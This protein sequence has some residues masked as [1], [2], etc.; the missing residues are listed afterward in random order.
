MPCGS[1]ALVN[2]PLKSSTAIGHAPPSDPLPVICDLE[3]MDVMATTEASSAF[4][5]FV[6]FYAL[7]SSP[8]LAS[9]LRINQMTILLSFEAGHLRSLP[10]Q[11]SQG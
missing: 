7:C 3:G 8:C 2:Q 11:K 9:S 10:L 6:L 4:V 1:Q 5:K